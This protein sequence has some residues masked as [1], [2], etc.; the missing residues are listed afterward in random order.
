MDLY[1]VTIQP[2]GT[3]II[4]TGMGKVQ[5]DISPSIDDFQKFVHAAHPHNAW[6]TE[7]VE[8]ANVG[9]LINTIQIGKIR[10]VSNGSYKDSYA[11]AAV[12]IKDHDRTCYMKSV[13]IAPRGPQVMS[14]YR[15]ELTGIYL[16]MFLLTQ[17]CHFKNVKLGEIQFG[18]DG[19]SALQCAFD[20]E[21]PSSLNDPGYNLIT[22]IHRLRQDLAITWQHCHIMGHQDEQSAFD[23]LDRW[24]QMNVEANTR[25]KSYM[26][27]A[28]ARP[29][30]Y[31]FYLEPWSILYEGR[32]IYHVPDIYDMIHEAQ[33]KMYWETKGKTD[34]R[35]IAMVDWEAFGRAHRSLP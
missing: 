13:G 35:A 32:E 30:H 15:G 20:F 29:R 23:Q 16:T 3:D 7:N 5:H 22:A 19:L 25:T 1:R 9:A 6:C 28:K 4:C 2:Q 14:A 24:S 27:V 31:H 17:L 34:P 33:A 11:T 8:I 18:Y 26:P 12:I 10:V 21:F